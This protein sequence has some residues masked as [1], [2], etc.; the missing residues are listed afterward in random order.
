MPAWTTEELDRVAG[1][2]EL[3]IASV[4]RDGTLR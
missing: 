2:E 3:E 1:A 4:Q